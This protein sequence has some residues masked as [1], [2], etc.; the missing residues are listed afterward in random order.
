M[1]GFPL[2][3]DFRASS[4]QGTGYRKNSDRERN[5]LLGS[6]GFTPNED[7]ALGLTVN[8]SQGSYGRPA[9]AISDINDTFAAVPKYVRVDDFSGTSMQLAADYA[10]S[11]RLSLRGWAFINRHEEEGNQY[12]NGDLNSFLADGSFQEQVETSVMGV[13]LQPKYDFGRA[14]A[15]ALSLGA[16]HDRWH[17]GG[18]RTEKPGPAPA[19]FTALSARESLATYSAGLEYAVS[20]LPGLGL[21]AGYGHYW[22]VRSEL[23][24]DDFSVLAGASYDLFKETRLKASFKRNVRFPSLGDLYDLSKGNTLLA[25]ERSYTY[26]A[27]VEQVLPLQSSIGLTGFYTKVNNL[28]QN[29]QAT[30]QNLNLA[31]VRFA[32]IEVAAATRCLKRLLL[33]ASYAYLH[34][35]DRSRAGRDEQQ[36]TPGEKLTLEAKYDFAGGFSPYLSLLHVGN[37]YFYTKNSVAEVQKAKLNDYTLVNVKLS[38]RVPHSRVTLYVGADNL[39]DENYETSYGLPQAGRFLYGGAEYLW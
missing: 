6:I 14:G 4:E 8:Y 19:T 30:G 24:D 32:G 36:Y 33:R 9:S 29:D 34:S 23:K 22:Q 12:D 31:D 26:E 18:Q 39:F 16:Q 20:P 21:V 7:L 27:G 1:D 11:H 15:V 37:Q 2:S 35:E 25:S 38:Q 17:N 10:A 5:N 3:D 13:T 28:I